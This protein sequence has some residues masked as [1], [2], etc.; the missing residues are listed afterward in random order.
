MMHAYP[1]PES[2]SQDDGPGDPVLQPYS[3]LELPGSLYVSGIAL[4]DDFRNRGGGTALLAIAREVARS[5]GLNRLSLLVFERNTAAM[6]LYQREGFAEI[7]RRAVVPHEFIHYTG[8]VVLMAGP[9]V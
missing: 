9:V 7:D 8:D 4:R 3:E 5:E 2:D 1:M 6:R